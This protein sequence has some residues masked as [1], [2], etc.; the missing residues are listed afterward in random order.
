[1]AKHAKVIA[2]N[3]FWRLKQ[4][5]ISQ[6]ELAKRVGLTPQY[7]SQIVNEKNDSPHMG[8]LEAIAE[9]LG[10]TFLELV[11]SPVERSQLEGK[12]STHT[13]VDCFER[14]REILA[15]LES[16]QE[17]EAYDRLRKKD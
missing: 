16:G 4:L 2:K 3:I 11:S 1:M 9:A 5:G 7:I 6:T 14:V 13:T 8:H 10:L 17:K 12:Q 15:L